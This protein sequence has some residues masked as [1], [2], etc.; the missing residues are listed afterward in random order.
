MPPDVI[1]EHRYPE[2]WGFLA[3]HGP[4]ALAVVHALMADADLGGGEVVVRASTRQ[5]AERLGFMS[6]DTVHRQIRTL[7]RAGVLELVPTT[8]VTFQAPTFR[9]HLTGT[10]IAVTRL[11]HSRH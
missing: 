8:A 5:V 6:K 10:G 1:V 9:L 3:D 2:A 11:A 7:R 4:T